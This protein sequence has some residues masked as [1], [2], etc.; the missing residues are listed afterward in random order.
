MKPKTYYIEYLNIQ[1]NVK[2]MHSTSK[3]TKSKI[4]YCVILSTGMPTPERLA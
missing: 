1:E 2:S 4:I 3:K